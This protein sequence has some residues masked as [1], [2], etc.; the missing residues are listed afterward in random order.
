MVVNL[1]LILMVA[2]I[3]AVLVMMRMKPKPQQPAASGP[4]RRPAPTP[5][6]TR[7]MLAPQQRSQSR[8]A[9][10]APATPAP[11]ISQQ[12]VQPAPVARQVQGAPTAVLAAPAMLLLEVTAGPE[13]GVPYMLM[14]GDNHVG[15]A[16]ACQIRLS[17]S[18]VSNQHAIVRI[19][20][21]QII[22]FDNASTNGTFIN[23]Q[24]VLG[25]V[26]LKE[27]DQVTLGQ[28]TLRLRT[29]VVPR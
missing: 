3:A 26:A 27:G 8:P 23:G 2:G 24:R 28:T 16:P 1:I 12:P 6:Q 4:A 18:T 20:P 15:R 22:L 25:P 9:P 21:G 19:T 5:M 29:Q 7:Q 10:A 13:K 14:Q 17:D 11:F